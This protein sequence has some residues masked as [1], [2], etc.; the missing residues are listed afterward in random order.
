MNIL[1]REL[2]SY[3]KGLIIWILCMAALIFI[4]TSE[5][6]AY[7]NNPEMKDILNAMPPQLLEAFSMAGANLTTV[8][9]FIS[10]A[11]LY[12]YLLLGLYGVLLGSGI[13]AKEERDKTAEF[14]LTLPVSR[15]K[16][17]TAKYSAMVL[18]NLVMNLATYGLI[19]L[20]LV[21]Y[22]KEEGF[23]GFMFLMMVGIYLIQMIFS[24]IG[25]AI[26][27][28]IKR[29]RK[30]GTYGT[31]LFFGLYIISVIIALNDHLTNLKYI[32]PFKYFEASQLLADQK[33]E[34][35]Y[36]V[37]SLGIILVATLITYLA[38]PRRDL[39]V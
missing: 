2:R 4:M 23:H 21:S 25:M 30:S 29:F 19:Y 20:S 13:L 17:I 9:G 35:V 36:V 18:L 16:A 5:F 15:T 1:K 38:Y 3:L 6:S 12:F 22:E 39:Q 26:S 37:L 14:F 33:L 27:S 31:S 10:I 32:T 24:S 34:L 28:L 8:G 7:Y 11:S